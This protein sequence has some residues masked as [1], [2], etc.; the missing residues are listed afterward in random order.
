MSQKVHT[1]L[2]S[3]SFENQIHDK[4]EIAGHQTINTPGYMEF[5]HKYKCMYTSMLYMYINIFVNTLKLYMYMH[6]I[7]SK[8]IIV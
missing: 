5:P 7:C 1:P 8:G 6:V 2:V 4:K 3:C